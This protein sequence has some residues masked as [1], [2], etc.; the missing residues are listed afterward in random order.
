MNY[1]RFAPIEENKLKKSNEK[2]RGREKKKEEW[3]VREG[4]TL[5]AA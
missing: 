4:E 1:E 2:E 5:V 3:K